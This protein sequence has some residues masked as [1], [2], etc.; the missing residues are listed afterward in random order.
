[1]PAVDRSTHPTSALPPH[2]S[3]GDIIAEK[4]RVVQVIGAG[5]MGVV[6]EAVH[7]HLEQP[8]AIKLLT[9]H[10]SRRADA[11][12]R[13]LREGRAAAALVSDHVVRIYDVGTLEDGAP[14]MVMELLR[15]VDLATLLD[16]VCLLPVVDAVEYVSQAAMAIAEAH[17]HGIVH[18]DLKPSNLFLTQRSDGTASVKVLD[19]GISKALDSDGSIDGSLTAPHSVIGS[20]AYMSPE[21]VRDAKHVDTRADI[22]SLGVILHE[23]TVGAHVFDADTLPGICAAI[24]T[25]AP[26]PLRALRPDV[27]ERLEAIVLKCLEKDPANRFQSAR[28]LLVALAPLRREPRPPLVDLVGTPSR[29]RVPTGLSNA[30]TLAETDSLL[31]RGTPSLEPS[32][33]NSG[34]DVGSRVQAWRTSTGW[35][36]RLLHVAGAVAAAA[37]IALVFGQH[38]RTHPA[39]ARRA[40]SGSV[41]HPTTEVRTFTLFVESVPTG[42]EVLAGDRKIGTTPLRVSVVQDE[43]RRRPATFAVR[44]AGYQPYSFVQGDSNDDVRLVA[45]LR[46]ESAPSPLTTESRSSTTALHK[47][48]PHVPVSSNA[49]PASDLRMHR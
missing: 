30:S 28:E 23:L 18:R 40:P 43:V 2:V 33:Q 8:V 16:D 19:F 11:A 38:A 22:W 39:P 12:A 42:A 9:V 17:A 1:M 24:V 4:Y 10:E 44:H 48:S 29:P 14:F 3:A 20:P 5:G 26:T 47:R 41:V 6:V 31:I 37:T 13:F 7:L 25:D 36:K 35:R 21:Q 45:A 32:T 49:V 27:P 15:G 34:I 46:Q